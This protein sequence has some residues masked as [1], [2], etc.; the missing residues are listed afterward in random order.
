MNA[1][2]RK[3]LGKIIAVTAEYYGKQLSQGALSLMLDDLSKLP[4]ELVAEGY[5]LYRANPK[6]VFFPLP[7]QIVDL[8]TPASTSSDEAAALADLVIRKIKSR[9]YVWTHGPTYQTENGEYTTTFAKALEIVLGE[10]GAMLVERKG[11]WVALC[12]EANESPMGVFKKQLLDTA[13]QV[14][15]DYKRVNSPLELQL[16]ESTKLLK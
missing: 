8:I 6:N 2:D 10:A 11:G 14:L 1:E 15:R 13:T 9:G 3:T 7:A 16:A 5:R 4:L 12:N